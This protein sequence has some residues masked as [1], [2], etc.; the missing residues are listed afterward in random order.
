MANVEDGVPVTSDTSFPLASVSKTVTGTALM[1]V[2]ETDAFELDDPIG[3]H[4]GFEVTHPTSA[5]PITFRHLLTHTSGIRDNWGI[6]P[7]SEGDPTVALRDYLEDYLDPD[8][9]L[10]DASRNYSSWGPGDGFSYSNI[11]VALA[12]HLVEA[13]IGIDFNDWCRDRIFEPLSMDHTGWYLRDLDDA[14]V[15]HPHDCYSGPCR[16]LRHYG[17]ADYPDGML[18]ASAEDMARFLAMTEQGGSLDGHLILKEET[19]AQMLTLQVPSQGQALIWYEANQ[20]GEIFWGHNGGDI[21]VSTNMF[22]RK[23]DGVGYMFWLNG[24]L[25]SWGPINEA[26]AAML[27]AADTLF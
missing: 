18:R 3:P 11:G 14:L 17:Y 10:Y 26:T 7:Y 20:G 9:D 8:G 23:E 5:A 12:G 19:V 16:T 24:E 22:V 1:Q 13:I 25:S 2:Y 27:E 15:A 4:L 21:G 6:M